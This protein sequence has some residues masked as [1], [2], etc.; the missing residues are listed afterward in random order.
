MATDPG[1]KAKLEKESAEVKKKQAAAAAVEELRNK[2]KSPSVSAAAAAAA[3]SL[4]VKPEFRAESSNRA[5]NVKTESSSAVAKQEKHHQDEG[6]KPTMETR[7]P[8]PSSMPYGYMPPGTPAVPGMP[9]P[10]F[11][12]PP[13]S[14]QLF[15]PMAGPQAAAAMA[16]M[17]GLYGPGGLGAAAAGSGAAGAAAAAAAAGIP[18][19]LAGLMR[20]PFMPPTSLPEDL[21][22]SAAALAAATGSGVSASKALDLLAQ[23][24]YPNHKIHELGSSSSA[25]SSSTATTTTASGSRLSTA[26]PSVASAAAAAALRKGSP[27]PSARGKSPPPLRHVHTHTH[28]HYGLGYPL[29]PPGVPGVP[30]AVPGLPPGVPGAP[31]AAHSPL[32]SPGFPSKCF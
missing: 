5:D 22:R 25:S 32:A 15:G 2:A 24:F 23:Q 10:P 20:P 13:G 1:Y 3:Q 9:R 4:A 18:P 27:S 6:V 21:S 11:S 16:A 30:G 29:I 31:S 17:A 28:T 7:G 14:E 26:S 12:L 8:P 19:H